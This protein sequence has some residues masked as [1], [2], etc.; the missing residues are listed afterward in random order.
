MEGN[1]DYQRQNAHQ[2]GRRPGPCEFALKF[3][4]EREFP[5]NAR[6]NCIKGWNE[7]SPTLSRKF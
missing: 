1:Q 5:F 7:R 4:F 6:G 3:F 2:H